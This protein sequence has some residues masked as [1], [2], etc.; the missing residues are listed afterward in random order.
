MPGCCDDIPKTE[1]ENTDQNI[2]KLVDMHFYN[3]SLVPLPNLMA[4][5]LVCMAQQKG[6][7]P[8]VPFEKDGPPSW[9]PI[10]VMHQTF[11][12]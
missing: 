8:E 3:A 12:I 9:V 5:I 4:E 10:H 7:L 6:K 1:L 11:L 2:A